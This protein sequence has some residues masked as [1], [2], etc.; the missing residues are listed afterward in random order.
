VWLLVLNAYLCSLNLIYKP[1]PVCPTYA[2]L[3][4]GHINLCAPELAYLSGGR[5][6]AISS[7]W[8]VLIVRQAT[9]RSVFLNKLVMNVVSLPI[10]VNDAH[11]CVEVLVS[12]TNVEV[13]RLRVN[14]LCVYGQETHCWIGCCEWYL[15]LPC[16]HNLSS[17]MCLVHY[18]GILSMRIYVRLGGLRCTG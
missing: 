18:I 15:F 4:S 10:Y 7:L 1:R 14:G 13:C 3:Q 5:C 16:I 11:L 17:G 2:V 6:W 8:I 9:F 12:L